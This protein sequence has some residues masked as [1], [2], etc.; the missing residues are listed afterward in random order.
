MYI[1][2]HPQHTVILHR[3][4]IRGATRIAES[5]RRRDSRRIVTPAVAIRD[6]NYDR[7][8]ATIPEAE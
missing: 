3:S 1:G 6:H 5:F 2:S 8:A 7:H 4:K